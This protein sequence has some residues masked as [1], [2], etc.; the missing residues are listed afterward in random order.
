MIT[1]DEAEQLIQSQI[2]SYGTE[3]VTLEASLGRVLME[4]LV[5]DRDL[6]PFNRVTMDGIAIQFGAFEKGIRSFT[7]KST[8]AAGEPPIDISAEKECIEIMTGAALPETADTIIRY[9]DIELKNGMAT[10]KVASISRGQNVH[11][12]GE[13]KKQNEIVA[14]APQVI[15]PALIGI[16]ASIG[17][18]MLCV[19]K[20][21]RA[22]IISTGDELVE[23]NEMPTPYQIRRSNSYT[24]KAV[25]QQYALH[26]DMMHLPDDA[27]ITRQ[28]I[29]RCLEDYDVILLSGGVSMGKFDYVPQALQ[30][31]SVQKYFHKVQQRPGKPFWFGAHSGGALVFAFPGNPVSAFMCL[32]RYFVPWLQSSLDIPPS[33]TC[34][35]LN[36]DVNFDP[37]LQYFMQ[38]KIR[39]DNGQLLATPVDGKGS[40]DFANL[41]EADAFMELPAEKSTFRKGEAYKVWMCKSS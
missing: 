4:N 37:P 25:L 26:A 8:Q 10:V 16:A 34:A 9:E 41:L 38:V 21:P 29:S 33:S 18:E 3:T 36:D 13:D 11:F 15:A 23:I 28:Q 14:F 7:I 30:E 27:E 31:L 5:A 2:K 39:N 12:Q 22:I 40:G 17:N 32:H 6:P 1:V 20:L 19:K 24:I 35:I